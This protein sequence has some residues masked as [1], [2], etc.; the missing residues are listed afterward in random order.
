MAM[1]VTHLA[2]SRIHIKENNRPINIIESTCYF[3]F[4]ALSGI[5]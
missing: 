4:E 1:A 2:K 5:N 3:R